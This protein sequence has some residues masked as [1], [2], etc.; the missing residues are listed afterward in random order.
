[1]S[2][3]HLDTLK[4]AQDRGIFSRSQQHKVKIKL[5]FTY[6]PFYSGYCTSCE[7]SVMNQLKTIFLKNKTI[8]NK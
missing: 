3:M 1:M 5:K 7:N 4:A 6:I 8:I 2:S